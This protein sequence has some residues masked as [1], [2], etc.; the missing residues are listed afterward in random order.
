M[1]CLT[2]RRARHVHLFRLEAEDPENI[3]YFLKK[4]LR[5]LL[6]CRVHDTVPKCSTELVLGSQKPI[7]AASLHLAEPQSNMY[8]RTDLVRVRSDD[9]ISPGVPCSNHC[10]RQKKKKVTV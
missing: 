6:A 3:F 2:K 7:R 8:W 5:E 1:I 9:L 4:E 10:P